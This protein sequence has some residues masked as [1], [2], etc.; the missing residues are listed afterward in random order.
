MFAHGAL[1]MN[2]DT[3]GKGHSK[4]DVKTEW[5]GLTNAPS[6]LVSERV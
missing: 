2:K 6:S 1:T 4:G 5:S 3:A